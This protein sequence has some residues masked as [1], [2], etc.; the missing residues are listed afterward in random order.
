MGVPEAEEKE[1][2]EEKISAGN[3]DGKLPKC[4]DTNLQIQKLQ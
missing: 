4:G 3:N 1:T 2:G